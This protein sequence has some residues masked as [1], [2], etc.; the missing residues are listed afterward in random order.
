MKKK[1][2]FL[3]GPPFISKLIRII[4]QIVDNQVDL[5]ISISLYSPKKSNEP[6]VKERCR[7]RKTSLQELKVLT[8]NTL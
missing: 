5:N 4:Q 7:H 6:P 1:I 2:Y 3:I 8:C